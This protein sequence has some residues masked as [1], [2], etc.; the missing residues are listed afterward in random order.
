MSD[1]T[2]P[3]FSEEAAVMIEAMKSQLLIVLLNRLGGS[4]TIPVNEID[5][6]DKL[7]MSMRINPEQEFEFEVLDKPHHL[8]N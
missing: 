3:E 7:V 6:T 5:D 1:P 2:I 8:N 4:I